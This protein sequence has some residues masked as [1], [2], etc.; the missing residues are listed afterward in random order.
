MRFNLRRSRCEPRVGIIG[1]P[2]TPGARRL[3]ADRQ[4]SRGRGWRGPSGPRTWRPC[5]P[6]AIVR[7]GAD[8]YVDGVDVAAD[9][10]R[11][12]SPSV[13]STNVGPAQRAH[14]AARRIP[15][16]NPASSRSA[17][18]RSQPAAP[19]PS[20]SA[21]TS[22]RRIPAMNRSPAI[23]A[24]SRPRAAATAPDSTPRPR[25]RGRWQV[26]S[27]AREVRAAERRPPGR[28]RARRRSFGSRPGPG[29][30]RAGRGR[31]AGEPRSGSWLRRPLSRR[32]PGARPAS[33]SSC[34]GRRRRCRWPA[35]GGRRRW[36]P[37]YPRREI[38]WT[39]R[40][41]GTPGAGIAPGT[42][43]GKPP[44]ATAVGT[45]PGAPAVKPQPRA[46]HRPDQGRPAT[47]RATRA[48]HDR[49]RQPTRPGSSSRS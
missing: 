7:A 43:E 18:T 15:A 45:I 4:Q 17:P 19:G 39:E 28:G 38:A 21:L 6:P 2:V 29:G 26:A 10:R 14:L 49:R 35:A 36:S 34:G 24:S 33:W 9:V 13:E 5:S 41:C 20:R 47:G 16:M 32:S 27:T 22:L 25:G 48:Q 44:T 12:L 1:R 31:L 37:R 23:T 42:T 30:P 46:P 11:S 3:P 40:D 8:G